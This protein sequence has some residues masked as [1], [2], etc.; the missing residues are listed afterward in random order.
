MPLTRATQPWTNIAK[1]VVE[2]LRAEHPKREKQTPTDPVKEETSK[3]A[4]FLAKKVDKPVIGQVCTGKEQR[5]RKQQG[6]LLYRKVFGFNHGFRGKRRLFHA[7]T[8]LLYVFGHPACSLILIYWKCCSHFFARLR[9]ISV[10]ALTLAVMRSKTGMICSTS[11]SDAILA[12]GLYT[13][14]TSGRASFISFFPV[15]VSRSR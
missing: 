7:S 13:A 11:S 1:Q 12:I 4:G 3:V 2:A 5:R 8:P 14:V 15:S 9:Y 6:K 10:S